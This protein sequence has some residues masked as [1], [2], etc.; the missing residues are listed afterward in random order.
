MIE[1]EILEDGERIVAL[2]IYM[3]FGQAFQ[4]RQD[5]YRQW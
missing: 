3:D 1:D 2:N 4:F 5:N